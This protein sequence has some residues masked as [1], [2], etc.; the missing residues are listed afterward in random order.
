MGPNGSGKS[1]LSHVI[2]GRPGYEVL[3]GLGHPRRRRPAGPGA[4]GAGPGR[5][6]P[7]HAVPDRGARRVARSTCSRR[8][9]PAPGRDTGDGAGADRRRGRAHR[10]RRALPPPGRQRRP[11]GRRE[12]AQRDAAARRA[13]AGDRHPRRARLRASTSTPCGPA[14]AGSR[15]PPRRPGS[16]CWPSPTT[17]GCCTSCTPTACT[18]SP[19]GAIQRSGGPELAAELETTGYAGWVADDADRRPT[20]DPFAD[21]LRLTAATRLAQLLAASAPR[22]VP[23]RRRGRRRP[24]TPP[25]TRRWPRPRTAPRCGP[26]RRPRRRRSRRPRV[27]RAPPMSSSR[28]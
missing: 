1:T 3:G 12:E 11:V 14:P 17:T 20:A 7:R 6:V 28:R 4:V 10:L 19:T 25:P 18:S 27:R 24:G 23:G 15:R 2:M 21:P 26:S 13:R 16:A 9:S 22:A 8:P 5:A